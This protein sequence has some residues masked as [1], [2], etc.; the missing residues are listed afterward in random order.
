MSIKDYVIGLSDENLRKA[1]REIIEWRGTTVL[2]LG[3]VRDIAC[4]MIEDGLTDDIHALRM[5]E[6]AV[7]ME[8]ATR[9]CNE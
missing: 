7:I 5:A 4:K 1:V 9:F 2:C 8:A 3:K 6:D